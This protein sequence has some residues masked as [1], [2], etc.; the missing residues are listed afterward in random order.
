MMDPLKRRIIVAVLWMANTII[1]L[2][3]IVLG[4]MHP[5]WY[6]DIENGTLAGF[7]LTDF[8]IGVFAFSL[9]TPIFMAYLVLV[10]R[11]DRVNKWLNFS[12]AV[13]IGLMS[14]VDFLHRS[15]QAIGISNWLV[16]LATN[17][18]LTIAV[19]YCWKLDRPSQRSATSLPRKHEGT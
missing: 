9:V 11:N 17:I 16:A 12:L 10:L 13:L 1:D 15:P 4:S 3:Q 8:T 6:R 14:W 7:P 2:I 5:Q 19:I 18:P